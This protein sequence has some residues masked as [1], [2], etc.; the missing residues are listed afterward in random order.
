MATG[1]YV[2][3]SSQRDAEV[4]DVEREKREHAESPAR[5]FEELK[6]IY[7]A[8]GLPEPLATEVAQRLTKVDPL[9]AHLR[10]ELGLTEQ[11]R[12]R[13]LQA[14]V[15]SAASFAS[16]AALPLALLYVV[17]RGHLALWIGCCALVLL[18]LLGAI[19]GRLGGANP[20]VAMLRVSIG[21]GLAMALTSAIGRLAGVA[22]G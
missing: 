20:W 5:E 8:R 1:E 13:P 21:G 17:P 2:S 19:G 18:A 22:T 15:V 6:G 16:G 12:A 14:A 11:F 10:D 3:V 9:G 7:Q 4:A